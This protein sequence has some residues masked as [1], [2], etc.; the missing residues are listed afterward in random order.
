MA[1]GIKAD[2][3]T[4]LNGEITLDKSNGPNVITKVLVRREGKQ[5]GKN[6]RVGSIKRSQSKVVGFEAGGTET[7]AKECG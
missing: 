1:D 6:Q 4:T 7:Y 2:N 3:Q 5:K